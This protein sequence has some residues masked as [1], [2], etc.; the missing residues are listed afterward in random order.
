LAIS[1]LVATESQWS[2]SGYRGWIQGYKFIVQGLAFP[3]PV[4]I[5][6]AWRSNNEN[7]ANIAMRRY[8]LVT[9]R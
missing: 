3:E 2:K 5:F 4:P 9:S 1:R 7:E 6:A 8:W